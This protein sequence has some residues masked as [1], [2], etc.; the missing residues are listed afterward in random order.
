[1]QRNHRALV[2]D[3]NEDIRDLLVLVLEQSGIEVRSAANGTQ[4]LE[5]V[6]SF[7]PDLVTLDLSLPDIDGTDVCREIRTFSDAYVVM[8]T[9][10]SDEID[11]LVGLELGAD[12]Y[13]AKPFSTREVAARVAALLRR[14]RLGIVPDSGPTSGPTSEPARRSD[15][16][17]AAPA[18]GIPLPDHVPEPVAP[19]PAAPREGLVVDRSRRMARLDGAALPLTPAEVDVLVAM[20]NRPSYAWS[21]RELG[22]AVWPGD[23]AESS[24]LLD[25]HIGNIRRKLEHAGGGRWITPVASGGYRFGPV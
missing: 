7:D 5:A 6:R 13:L 18:A 24:F 20:A 22:S 2:V 23:F 8:I 19:A 14:P 25:V 3:D 17:P 9:A 21:S 1:V 11:R 12:D 10:R 4:A 15:P 16:G